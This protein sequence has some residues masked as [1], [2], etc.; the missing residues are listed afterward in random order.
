VEGFNSA[1]LSELVF[2]GALARSSEPNYV[3]HHLFTRKTW[4]DVYHYDD[5]GNLSGWTRYDG[6]RVTNFTEAGLMV[7]ELD[8]ANRP[9]K[10]QTVRY[11]AK[12]AASVGH[13]STLEIVA[14]DEVISYAYDT[15]ARV[16]TSRIQVKA[17]Q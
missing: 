6:R 9:R 7:L 11:V 16:E 14:G 12:P 5:R 2:P 15:G 10:V 17:K 3:D 1:L 13:P 8:N 4:R